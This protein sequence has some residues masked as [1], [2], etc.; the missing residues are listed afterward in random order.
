MTAIRSDPAQW[1]KLDAAQKRII[2]S[3]IRDMTLSGVGLDGPSRERFKVRP[4]ADFLHRFSTQIGPRCDDAMICLE[5]IVH[6]MSYTHCPMVAFTCF[7]AY[8]VGLDG[9]SRERFKVRPH[10]DFLHRV[11]TQ[12]GP[13]CDAA[14]ICLER[15]VH[16]M[17]YTHCPIVAFTC[18]TAYA[19]GLDGPSRERFKVGGRRACL[20][21]LVVL[22]RMLR[23]GTR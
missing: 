3:S 1:G 15:I 4:P 16:L 22:A 9:P 12:I 8:G 23:I 17:S 5:R 6:L 21:D 7:T 10:A 14:I 20:I 11:S 13:R 19:V 18:F 2:E